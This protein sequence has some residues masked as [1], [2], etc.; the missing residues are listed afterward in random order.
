MKLF[1]FRLKPVSYAGFNDI[2]FVPIN[3][4]IIVCATTI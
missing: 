1:E 3:V 4:Q 2:P